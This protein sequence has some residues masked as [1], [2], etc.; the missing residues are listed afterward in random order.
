MGPWS[1]PPFP[2]RESYKA[3]THAPVKPGLGVSLEWVLIGSPNTFNDIRASAQVQRSARLYYLALSWQEAKGKVVW[4]TIASFL[5]VHKSVTDE[6]LGFSKKTSFICSK[7]ENREQF[8]RASPQKTLKL[9]LLSIH[10][11]EI[12]LTFSNTLY[13]RLNCCSTIFVSPVF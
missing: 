8:K 4:H 7:A 6:S 5:S 3:F 11:A 13:Y 9:T 12:P 1:S 10:S 2:A